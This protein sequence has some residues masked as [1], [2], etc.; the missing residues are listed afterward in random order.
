MVDETINPQIKPGSEGGIQALR[1]RAPVDLAPA[2]AAQAAAVASEADQGEFAWTNGAFAQDLIQQQSR[3]LEKLHSKVLADRDPEPLHQMRVSLRRLRTALLQFGAALELPAS[4]SERRIAAVARRTSR[5]RDLDVLRLRLRDQLLPLLPGD[6]QRSL[7]RAMK[8]LGRDRARAFS[9]LV[10]GLHSSRYRT[11]LNQLKTWQKHPR[12]TPLGQRSLL[13][14]LVDWQ[15][16]FTAGLALHPGWGEED[17][18]AEVL[19]GLRKR[20]KAARYSL[21]NFECWCS[22]PLLAW[23]NDLRQAQDHLGELHDLQLFNRNLAAC[24]G[25]RKRSALPVLRAEIEGQTLQ[26]WRCWRELSQ[27][28]LR[29]SHRHSLQRELLALGQRDHRFGDDVQ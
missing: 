4:V 17:P 12:F 20:I 29:D 3:R 21:E 9:R 8:R 1:I 28:L 22:P 14:W 19:H 7:E 6:E 10:D 27:R 2:F 13:P 5:C 18:N 16:P 26:H 23:I 11:L 25:R 15:A 24:V